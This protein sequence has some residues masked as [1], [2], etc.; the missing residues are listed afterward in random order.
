VKPFKPVARTVGFS[1]A[2]AVLPL[3]LNATVAGADGRGWGQ[4]GWQQGGWEQGSGSGTVTAETQPNSATACDADNSC[5]FAISG[6]GATGG[7][8]GGIGEFA[9]QAEL[10]ADLTGGTS[11]GFGGECYPLSGSL[12]LSPTQGRW[13]SGNLVVYVQGQDCAVGSSATLS[14][15]NATYVVDGVDSTGR[16]AGAT[17]A[18]TVSAS[19]DTSRTPPAFGFAFSG[20]L[21]GMGHGNPGQN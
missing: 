17:G 3:I 18:G 6:T 14:A 15:I 20:S 10:T 8:F 19:V 2:V 9:L 13:S 5:Q 1:A 12:T 16:F 21:Q 11:N 7:F 4:G